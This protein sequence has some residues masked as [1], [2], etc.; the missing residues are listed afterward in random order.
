[1][2]QSNDKFKR[3]FDFYIIL[4]VLIAAIIVPYRLSFNFEESKTLNTFSY[5][6]KVSFFVD[7]I[8]TFFTS[9]LDDDQFKTY[10]T[11]KSIAT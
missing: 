6:S 10:D 3:I 7:I 8:L 9:Y 1:M 11:Y 5:I 2:I 4:L